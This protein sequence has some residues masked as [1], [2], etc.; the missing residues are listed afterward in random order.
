MK[1]YP[2]PIAPRFLCFTFFAFIII[3]SCSKD[4]DEFEKT[5]L[6]ES[7]TTVKELVK[8]EEKPDVTTEE[9]VKDEEALDVLVEKVYETRTTV[10]PAINDAH[11]QGDVGFNENTVRLEEGRRTS[12]LMFDLSPIDSIGG[13]VNTTNLEFTVDSD[14][15][16]GTVSVYKAISNDW[17]EDKLTAKTAPETEVLVGK[18]AAQYEVGQTQEVAIDTAFVRNEIL[19]LILTHEQGNDL[20]F[21]SKENPNGKGPALMVTYSAPQDA[22]A[23]II[24]EEVEKELQ[25]DIATEDIKTPSEDIAEESAEKEESTNL[26]EANS[27]VVATEE[28]AFEEAPTEQDTTEETEEKAQEEESKVEEATKEEITDQ[29]ITKEK[30]TEEDIKVDEETKD[31]GIT[32][33]ES[34]NEEINSEPDAPINESP[35]AVAEAS[36]T[37]GDAPLKVSF[38]GNNSSDDLGIKNY[39]W[40]FR[41]GSTSTEANPT[42]TFEKTGTLQVRLTITDNQGAS[43]TDTVTITINEKEENKEPNALVSANPTA[44]EATLAVQFKGSNSNDD[45][46][47]EKYFWDFKDGSTTT[48]ANPSHSF[49]KAGTYEVELSVTDDE[50]LTDTETVTIKVSEKENKAPKAVA[51]GSPLTGDAP[52]EVQFKSSDSNDD[53]E[54]TSYFW[55]FKDGSTTTNKNPSHTF[56]EPGEYDVELSVKDAEG[57]TDAT[58]V[59]VTVNQRPVDTGGGDTNDGGNDT[60]GSGGGGSSSGSGSTSGGSTSESAGNY[61]SG[62]VLASSFGFKSG[63]ATAAFEAAI[64]S[65]SSY[66]VIDK[67]SSDWII[68]PTR[69]FDL[70]NMTIVF[71]PGVTLRAKSGAFKEGARLFKLSGARNVTIEGTG[72]TFKM[73]KNEYTSGEQRHAF[74]MDMC[75]GITVRGLTI[76]DS[77]GAGIKLMGDT[78]SGYCQ[79]IILENIRSLNNRRDGI[80]ITS[81]QDVWVRNSE[82]SGSSGTRPEAGVVLESDTANEKLVNINFTNCKFADNE[83]AG[84]HFSTNKMNGGSRS[85][86][87]KVVDSEFS[88]NAISPPSGFLPTEVEVGGGSGTNVVGGEIRFERVKFNGSR[89]GI[90]FTRKSANGF[91]AVF[92]DCEARNVVTSNAVSPIRMEAHIDRNTLGGIEFDNFY[93]QYNRDVPFMQIQAPSKGGSFN[94]KDVKG[95]FN[96]KEPNDNPLAYKGGYSPSQNQ[97]VT[98]DYNH[99]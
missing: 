55:D 64:N 66:V 36:P 29:T 32:V 47:I 65:G 76:R 95:S 37:N 94:V 30:T 42:H 99:N 17:S 11:L 33:E 80:T 89:G 49:S 40:D 15:G 70:Q 43:H 23:I 12:Y 35:I 39:V 81:A 62:A 85:V 77:G 87:I 72:A 54:I 26:A 93:I 67:Q 59:K 28:T 48:N 97:N 51:S 8:E 68:R 10:F 98:I 5:V 4:N 53:T 73:N 50:G 2:T 57:L 86:S 56:S 7:E 83:S 21:A 52:L 19:T 14:E 58:T 71:E 25:A 84:I 20:A 61:P 18:L 3:L 44:G 6:D 16:N 38:K 92:K 46:K 90:V 60:S 69:F 13:T 22:E 1:F 24:D 9:I 78:N 75:N 79:N 91:K 34:T 63:D 74:E 41:D 82:F 88:N 45:T 96:I 31:Q 27:E